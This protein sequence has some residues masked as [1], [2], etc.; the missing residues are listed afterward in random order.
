MKITIECDHCFK[1]IVVDDDE[2][3]IDGASPFQ[4]DIPWDWSLTTDSS[5]RQ[6]LLCPFGTAAF[7]VVKAQRKLER[8]PEPGETKDPPWL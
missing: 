2:I 3:V 1:A 7:E 4:P 6:L 8:L 5:G